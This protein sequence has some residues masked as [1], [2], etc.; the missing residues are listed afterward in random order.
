MIYIDVKRPGQKKSCKHSG[1]L[2]ILTL[3]MVMQYLI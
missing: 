1:F 2:I 3:K